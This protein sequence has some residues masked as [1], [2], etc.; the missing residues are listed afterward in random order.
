MIFKIADGR[1][2]LYQWD[3]NRQVI[4]DDPT[5]TEVH[6][7]NG[8]EDYSLVVKVVDGKAN[9]PNILLQNS[10]DIK[11]FAYDG[12]STR[13]DAV[14]EVKAKARPSDYVYTE[15]QEY[16]IEYYLKQAIDEAKANGEFNGDKGDKGDKGDPGPQG[17]QGEPGPQGE[18]GPKG[19]TG[20]QGEQGPIGPAGPTGPKGEQGLQG[21][22]GTKGDTGTR[23]ST[24]TSGI[25][26]PNHTSE[27]IINDK[28]L[29]T[30]NGEV[31]NF[32]GTRWELIGTLKGPQGIQGP[33]GPRGVQGPQG[34]IGPKGDPG[35]RGSAG[36][37]GSVGPA[38]PQGI[39]GPKGDKGDPF[40]YDMFTAEQLEALRGP[41]G[42]QG[43]PGPQGPAGPAG[44]SGSGGPVSIKVNGQTYD[45]DAS[46]LIT[47]PNYPANTSELT[48]D[49][50]FITSDALNGYATEKYVDDAIAAIDI[51]GGGGTDG[52]GK[53]LYQ[54]TIYI[55]ADGLQLG[56]RDPSVYT[57]FVCD[58]AAEFTFESFVNY[59]NNTKATIAVSG[60]II[61]DSNTTKAKV[62]PLEIIKVDTNGTSVSV[63]YR[64][65][66]DNNS[67]SPEFR[68]WI[69]T[70]TNIV[71][72][73][74]TVT[75]I[76][77]ASVGEGGGSDVK[78]VFCLDMTGAAFNYD[79]AFTQEIKDFVAYWKANGGK[80]AVFVKGVSG[81]EGFVPVD[82]T[83]YSS[84]NGFLLK[85][86]VS[87]DMFN[88]A[89]NTMLQG[90]DYGYDA[91]YLKCSN[92]V[93]CKNAYY[94]SHIQLGKWTFTTDIYLSDPYNTKELYIAV[95]D[96]QTNN[97][98]TSYYVSNV[99][100]GD[101]TYTNYAF[102][103]SVA[104]AEGS[105]APYW[106]FN[107]SSINI[108]GFDSGYEIVTIAYKI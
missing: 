51:P 79:K 16:T 38:G 60:S 101:A 2:F 23:G 50:G 37:D 107:G 7:S 67:S 4:V 14:F 74:D 78:E 77:K 86:F 1:D 5:I 75:L 66:I 85:P 95:K 47:L 29:N 35:E 84:E 93:Y 73:T 80:C 24:W 64:Y 21:V 28:Y 87:P 69:I 100:I 70:S 96:S 11:V 54:H 81:Y 91:F 42:P 97:I 59:L 19:D 3:L 61:Y 98:C 15:E 46:G 27:D 9:V 39:A 52:S 89:L 31:Y 82:V 45:K 49:S 17:P 12:E 40:T 26:T 34:P 90:S 105:Q 76:G 68:P 10:F 22:Q 30:F 36:R 71:S 94:L 48:N 104:K 32:N 99:S 65:D 83:Y 20:P 55:G 43:E 72:F 41:Q 13:Y 88:S 6:F 18:Q 33:A 63:Y 44:G 103:M 57:T 106:Y 108:S 25:G 92:E 58:R 102:N 56:Y 62:L 53:P 8:L